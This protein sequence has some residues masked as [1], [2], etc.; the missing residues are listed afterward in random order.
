MQSIRNP[1]HVLTDHKD[2]EYFTTTK[3]L[4]WRQ[5]RWSQFVSQFDFKMV[6][7]PGRAG[8][9][10]D[11]LTR[12]SGDLPKKG[13][14]QLEHNEQV[15]LKLRNILRLEIR[16]GQNAL[17]VDLRPTEEWKEKLQLNLRLL[18]DTPPRDRH[19]SLQKLFDEAYKTDPFPT[20]ILTCLQNGT[21]HH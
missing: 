12:R 6:Y 19:T 21:Q 3:F 16:I 2:L 10:P 9:K 11:A 20:E 8:D 5:T 4:N 13:D 7:R 1:I 18:A 15:L 17:V 14:E